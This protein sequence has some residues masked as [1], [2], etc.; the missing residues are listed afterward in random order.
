MVQWKGSMYANRAFV[1][2]EMAPEAIQASYHPFSGVATATCCTSFFILPAFATPV[3]SKQFLQIHLSIPQE[4]STQRIHLGGSQIIEDHPDKTITYP[5][6]SLG[7]RWTRLLLIQM[8]LVRGI[9]VVVAFF[10]AVAC[11]GG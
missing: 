9:E 11:F 2:Y 1:T 6:P 7:F 10:I 5:W 4:P 3:P 8:A